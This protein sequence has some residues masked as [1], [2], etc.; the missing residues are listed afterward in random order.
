[1]I[2]MECDRIACENEAER[3]WISIKGSAYGIQ[4]SV[5]QWYNGWIVINSCPLYSHDIFSETFT[6]KWINYFECTMI[7]SG[8]H[9]A[10]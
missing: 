5:E 10:G 6:P 9:E 2:F 7:I 3:E 8:L 1:M 4:N